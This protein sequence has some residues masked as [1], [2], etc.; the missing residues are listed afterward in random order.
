MQR[1]EAT[2]FSPS[3]SVCHALARLDDVGDVVG[4][5]LLVLVRL[6]LVAEDHGAD[7]DCGARV[8]PGAVGGVV[9]GA[10]LA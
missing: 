10:M 7:R 4:V 2:L 5:V 9:A 6:L 3:Q 1:G 8:A